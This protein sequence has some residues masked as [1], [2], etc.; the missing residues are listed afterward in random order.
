MAWI[1]IPN[2]SVKYFDKLV[3]HKIGSKIGKVNK[4]DRN[5]ESMDRG[6]YVRF[7]VEVDLSKLLLSKFKLNGRVWKIQYEGLKLICFKCGHLG[8][9][10]DNCAAFQSK[11]DGSLQ[12]MESTSGDGNAAKVPNVPEAQQNRPEI[13]KKYGDWMLVSRTGRRNTPKGISGGKSITVEGTKGPS[14]GEKLTE[15]SIVMAATAKGKG[16]GPKE[17]VVTQGE[18]DREPQGSRFEVLDVEDMDISERAIPEERTPEV[19]PQLHT[20]IVQDT[21]NKEAVHN[22]EGDKEVCGVKSPSME[23]FHSMEKILLSRDNDISPNQC[24][25]GKGKISSS[26]ISFFPKDKSCE[27]VGLSQ[28][29]RNPK[30]IPSKVQPVR[31]PKFKKELS[32]KTSLHRG[33]GKENIHVGI[34]TLKKAVS[35]RVTTQRREV[36]DGDSQHGA[37]PHYFGIQDSTSGGV[38]CGAPIGGTVNDCSSSDCQSSAVGD[39]L[40]YPT[41]ERKSILDDGGRLAVHNGRPNEGLEGDVPCFIE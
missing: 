35:E 33:V 21:I 32:R 19:I 37:N 3:L 7:C 39:E 38:L 26:K 1:R 2:L 18:K 11:A 31:A 30:D 28:S 24:M 29:V 15:P 9:K 5:T 13:H 17:K 25:E 22:Q 36:G 23:G 20:P 14:N 16:L 4:I 8:H 40:V 10:E 34:H 12:I 27:S 6:Q 41:G